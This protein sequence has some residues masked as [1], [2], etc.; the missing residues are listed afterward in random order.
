MCIW[1]C[2]L[3]KWTKR[4]SKYS[5]FLHYNTNLRPYGIHFYF[6]RIED[7]TREL[8][9]FSAFVTVESIAVE[10]RVS[11]EGPGVSWLSRT[12]KGLEVGP[13]EIEINLQNGGQMPICLP[14]N[15]LYPLSSL[16]NIL[17]IFQVVWNFPFCIFYVK[18]K[19]KQKK[20]H[21]LWQDQFEVLSRSSH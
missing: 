13:C 16:K 2:V 8:T 1:A 14:Q 3:D 20:W 6:P 9:C 21:F 17:Y 4:Q 11:C 19:D 10:V 18:S 5:F 7:S 12:A 15:G